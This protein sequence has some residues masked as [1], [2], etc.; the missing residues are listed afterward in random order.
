MK[1][2]SYYAETPKITRILAELEKEERDNVSYA[3]E[4]AQTADGAGI[5]QT[6]T[7]ELVEASD[8]A[9]R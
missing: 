7:G 8:A 2:K 9:A 1:S 6:D 4:T 5:R 3:N